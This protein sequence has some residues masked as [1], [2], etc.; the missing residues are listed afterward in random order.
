MEQNPRGF[1]G[2]MLI[3]FHWAPG[4]FDGNWLV[5]V[6]TRWSLDGSKARHIAVTIYTCLHALGGGLLRTLS[7][8]L[9]PAFHKADRDR[10]GGGGGEFRNPFSGRNKEADDSSFLLLQFQAPTKTDAETAKRRPSST[11][12][13]MVMSGS[14]A[15]TP[16]VCAPNPKPQGSTMAASS[17]LPP[18]EK[19]LDP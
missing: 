17:D 3:M 9:G 12:E 10:G 4:G 14:G 13:G 15:R 8:V 18:V 7:P 6:S 11:M 2:A 1:L 5:C 16:R 19:T